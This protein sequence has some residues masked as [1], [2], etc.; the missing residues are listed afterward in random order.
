MGATFTLVDFHP[1][2][3]RACCV[4]GSAETVLR[5][6]IYSQVPCSMPDIGIR[7]VGAGPKHTAG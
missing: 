1:D 5:G 2:P 4:A 7:T 6:A 3:R